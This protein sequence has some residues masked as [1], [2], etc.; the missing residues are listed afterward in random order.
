MGA[1]YD[2]SPTPTLWPGLLVATAAL[3]LVLSLV[4][5]DH[6]IACQLPTNGSDVAGAVQLGNDVAQE[7][8]EVRL[9]RP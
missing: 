8:T 7:R 4:R 1:T 2:S 6:R 3:A 5:P 9:S